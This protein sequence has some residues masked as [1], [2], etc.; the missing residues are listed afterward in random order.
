MKRRLRERARQRGGLQLLPGQPDILVLGTGSFAARIVFDLAA[1]ASR[2]I[3]V[4]I[5]GRNRER[6][7]WLRT[8]ANARAVVFGRSAIFF[9]RI[10]DLLAH[11]DVVA[12]IGRDRPTVISHRHA[13]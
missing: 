12:L 3:S 5:A 4:A 2:P 10:V 6:L 11:D 8:A 9:T 1:T 7:A 13:R